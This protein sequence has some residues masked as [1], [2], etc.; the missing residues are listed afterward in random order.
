MLDERQEIAE[1]RVQE[2]R[3]G[4]MCRVDALEERVVGAV[5]SAKES[6]RQTAGSIRTAVTDVKSGAQDMMQQA[7]DGLR[8]VLDVPQHIR[9]NPWPS[10]GIAAFAGFIAG[11]WRRDRSSTPS[12]TMPQRSNSAGAG[13]FGDLSGVLKRELLNIGESAILAASHAVKDNIRAASARFASQGAHEHNGLCH[14]M[15]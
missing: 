12:E 2:A 11:A 10:V 13:L 6:V 9:S 5:H 3:D 8:Q 4:L 7:T 15:G 14:E 1:R